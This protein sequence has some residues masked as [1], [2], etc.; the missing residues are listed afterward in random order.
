MENY[1]I[2]KVRVSLG[3]LLN[4]VEIM[5]CEYKRARLL[6]PFERYTLSKLQD[7]I[8]RKGIQIMNVRQ[9]LESYQL[10]FLF[11]S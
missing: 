4:E 6:F 7:D 11:G 5:K 1:S 2:V 9:E 8:R 10:E 3:Q